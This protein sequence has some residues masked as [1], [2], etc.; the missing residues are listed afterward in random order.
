MYEQGR[1]VRVGL[2]GETPVSIL[3]ASYAGADGQQMYLQGGS[4]CCTHVTNPSDAAL[5]IA[6]SFAPAA[7]CSTR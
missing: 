2:A 3:Y 1:A 7:T 6:T 5:K 4:F